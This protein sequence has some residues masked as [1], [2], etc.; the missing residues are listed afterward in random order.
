MNPFHNSVSSRAWIDPITNVIRPRGVVLR[1]DLKG[2][3][4]GP[5]PPNT[6]QPFVHEFTHHWCFHSAVGLAL[7]LLRFRSLRRPPI[8]NKET[9]PLLFDEMLTVDTMLELIRPLSEGLALFAEYDIAPGTSSICSTPLTFMSIA[10]SART[11]QIDLSLPK[12]AYELTDRLVNLR[13]N[14]DSL[15]R[16]INFLSYSSTAP[17]SAY[18]DGYMTVKR[19]YL[20]LSQSVPALADTDLFL[21]YLRSYLFEDYGMVA[22]LAGEDG[23][24]FHR[25]VALIERLDQRLAE[26]YNPNLAE[27]V[28][29]FE[30]FN[31]RPPNGARSNGIPGL[32]L[33]SG[34]LE[35]GLKIQE[36]LLSELKDDAQAEPT[37][38]QLSD[39]QRTWLSRRSLVYVA[40]EPAKVQVRN[41]VVSVWPDPP[42]QEFPLFT[43]LA[44]VA[45]AADTEGRESGWVSLVLQPQDG[46][47]AVVIGIGSRTT[48]IHWPPAMVD[49][50]QEITEL[51]TDPACS[52]VVMQENHELIKNWV[53]GY[54][55]GA[56]EP[57]KTWIAQT[58]R[59]TQSALKRIA[60]RFLGRWG[61][62]QKAA[63]RCLRGT[64]YLWDLFDGDKKMFETFV[65][66]G[67]MRN[68][69][70]LLPSF[71]AAL[72]KQGWDVGEA[73]R[74][75]IQIQA[76]GV[77]LVRNDQGVFRWLL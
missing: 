19:L 9:A 54:L 38:R 29:I 26:L 64:N 68:F 6:V 25:Q 23:N 15:I 4:L 76:K 61:E 35:H 28:A 1:R 42:D 77:S 31:D 63:L 75:A 66:L 43:G 60:D 46:L 12:G 17:R 51:L 62:D 34:E 72:S 45:G 59:S 3:L 22:I 50:G 10:M 67:V 2:F 70:V 5:W 73:L 65:A 55:Q 8:T 27:N 39:V 49:H 71:S 58:R 57:M 41:G 20:D 44:S 36:S 74:V 16:K 30:Q 40:S 33:S 37:I 32:G 56:P 13:L 11:Q 18:L 48:A 14:R 69:D 52:P 24:T 47:F 7:A 21:C 53:D